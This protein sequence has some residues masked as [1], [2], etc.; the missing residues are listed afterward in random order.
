MAEAETHFAR[1]EDPLAGI[2]VSPWAPAVG[3]RISGY[4]YDGKQV[5]EAVQSL[6]RAALYE[7]GIVIFEPGTVTDE[8]YADFVTFLGTRV[9]YSGERVIDATGVARPGFMIDSDLDDYLRNH[10]WH[11]D[12]GFTVNPPAFTGLFAV[13]VPGFGGDTIYSNATKAYENFDP[14]FQAYLDGLTAVTFAD[15]TGHLIRLRDPAELAAAHAKYPAHEEPVIRV[16]PRTGRKQ[17][18]VNES[19]THYIKGVSRNVSQHILGILFE[20]VKRPETTA[21][22]SWSDGTFALWDNRVVQ[23]RVI[24]DYDAN[25]RRLL[26]RVTVAEK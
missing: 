7:H 18:A 13:K 12:G 17:I 19:Y 10:I 1:A 5:P 21:R 3:A 15:A 16:H 8:T 9:N 22:L 14:L 24:K 23:H 2:R 20:A 6:V 26:Y 25:Q 11:T 4:R